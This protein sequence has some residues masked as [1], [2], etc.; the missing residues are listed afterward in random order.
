MK[1]Q[2]QQYPDQADRDTDWPLAPP[3]ETDLPGGDYVL[4]YRGAKKDQWFGQHKVR[5]LFEIVGPHE[6]AGSHIPLFATL[7]ERPSPRCKYYAIWVKANGGPPRRGDRMSPNVFHGYWRG[8]IAWSVP[9]SG[10]H[11]MPQVVELIERAAGGRAR[12]S[13]ADGKRV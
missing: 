3:S 13:P 2:R 10:G 5:L 1:S 9:K 11:P 8:R 4:A 7:E 6:C 12:S